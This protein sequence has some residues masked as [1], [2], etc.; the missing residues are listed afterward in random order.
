MLKKFGHQLWEN[1]ICSH[2]IENCYFSYIESKIYFARRLKKTILDLEN[3]RFSI[4][5][6]INF[7]VTLGN[8]LTFFSLSFFICL[9]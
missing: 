7:W 1:S 5:V 3:L 2:Y 6:N 8:S 4:H 9:R